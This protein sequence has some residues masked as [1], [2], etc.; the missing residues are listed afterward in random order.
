[1]RASW[2][3]RASR[4]CCRTASVGLVAITHMSNVLGTYTP[5]ERIVALA[6]AHGAKVL[7][8]GS[9][10]VVHRRDRRAGAGRRFLRLHRPQA[11]WPDRHRR[12]LGTARAA[13]GDAAL[14]GRR[15]HDLLRDLR[16]NHLGAGA[17]QVRGGHAGDPGGHRPGRGD[18]LCRG[19]RL[20]RHRGARGGTDR[21]CPRAAVRDRGPADHRAG[22]G[23][24]RRDL[25]HAG[26][27]ACA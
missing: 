20:R 24:R 19:D 25:L 17:A 10:A 14:H 18:P 27:R 5:A 9:Q 11:V 22:A 2:T 3:W 13:G 26:R 4:R 21:A 1:M 16:A 6:H 7:F 23:S 8:D 12:A 15:R